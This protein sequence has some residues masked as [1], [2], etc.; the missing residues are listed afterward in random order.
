MA[1]SL[2]GRIATTGGLSKWLSGDADLLHTHR[3][4]ALSDAVVEDSARRIASLR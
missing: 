2:D 1:Q 4:R 3:M